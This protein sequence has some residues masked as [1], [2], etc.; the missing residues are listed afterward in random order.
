MG[1]IDGS[2]LSKSF[3]LFNIY[4]RLNKGEFINKRQ[5]AG[6]FFVNEK[7]IQRDIEDLRA[8]IAEK[9]FDVDTTIKYDVQKQG[10]FL[11]KFTEH[12]LTNQEIFA[13]AKIILESRAFNGD[14]LDQLLDHLIFQAA[15]RKERENI[16]D[17][18]L[19]EKHHYVPL[20][21]KTP[22]LNRIWELNNYIK[23]REIINIEYRRQDNKKVDR[24]IKPLAIVF[25]E[26]YFYLIALLKKSKDVTP[27]VFRIDRIDKVISTK[28]NFTVLP[29][30]NRFE[31]G[32]FRKKVQ[33]M[34]PGKS[35]EIEF[36][37]WGPSL[38]AVC[39]RL[40]TAK[41]IGQEGEKAI[42]RATVFGKGIKMWLLSQAEFLEVRKPKSLR[43][44][45]KDIISRMSIN[46]E[47]T[48]N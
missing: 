39:D 2:N 22:L 29:Y 36:Y 12:W 19:N 47:G 4:E 28:E 30:K 5:L 20:Q 14:E 23:V 45:M 10:Y 11:T 16:E 37:F 43:Q 17:L 46:Y 38:E 25:S 44:E 15:T 13:L 21:H 1:S 26:F 40:P 33:F 3:R 32:E 41:V 8:Y 35:M 9:Q 42:V 48:C 27:I 34:Y 7:T 31:E 18:I 24:T 6:E